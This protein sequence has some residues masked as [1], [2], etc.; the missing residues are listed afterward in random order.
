MDERASIRKPQPT[1]QDVVKLQT[2]WA[3]QVPHLKQG[4]YAD[5]LPLHEVEYSS[6]SIIGS[7]ERTS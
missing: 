7:Q 5:G 4:T 3:G 2:K 1:L 6:K